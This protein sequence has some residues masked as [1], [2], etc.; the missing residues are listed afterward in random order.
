M[1]PLA[2]SDALLLSNQLDRGL[3]NGNATR[4]RGVSPRSRAP[5]R[6]TCSGSLGDI[7]CECSGAAMVLLVAGM[8]SDESGILRRVTGVVGQVGVQFSTSTLTV[9]PVQNG[10]SSRCT[11]IASRRSSDTTLS[12][13]W[14]VPPT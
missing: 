1:V 13:K 4:P 8:P 12:I 7:T 9:S 14:C 5:T 2:E 3:L 10:E 6:L 11:G